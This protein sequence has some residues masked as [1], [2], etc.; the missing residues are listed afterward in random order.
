M[1]DKGVCRTALATLGLLKIQQIRD[2]ESVTVCGSEEKEEEKKEEKEKKSCVMC[3]VPIQ[4]VKTIKTVKYRQ[5]SH[6]TLRSQFCFFFQ[7]I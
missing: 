5:G 2:T 6:L 3:N 1:N 4:T 7:V